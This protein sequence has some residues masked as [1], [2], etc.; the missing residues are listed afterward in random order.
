LMLPRLLRAAN[1]RPRYMQ[2]GPKVAEQGKRPRGK[3]NLVAI[4]DFV[5]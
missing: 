4:G 1:S 5:A 2:R 3:S